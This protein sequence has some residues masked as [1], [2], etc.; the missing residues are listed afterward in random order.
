MHNALFALSLSLSYA[1]CTKSVITKTN[2]I[3]CLFFFLRAHEFNFAYQRYAR[4]RWL[5]SSVSTFNETMRHNIHLHN[6]S[7]NYYY[8]YH[9]H[10]SFFFIANVQNF[11]SI[12]IALSLLLS[13]TICIYICIYIFAFYFRMPEC[14]G[15]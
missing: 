9:G 2:T 15:S 6:F 8:T 12:F 13:L 1:I 14:T 11:I 5:L 4:Y 3:R 7:F 10:F